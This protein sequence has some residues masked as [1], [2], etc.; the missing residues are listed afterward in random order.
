[1]YRIVKSLTRFKL[2]AKKHVYG[3]FIKVIIKE[4]VR[5]KEG[6]VCL[7]SRFR[8]LKPNN[9]YSKRNLVPAECGVHFLPCMK[10]V[11]KRT[12][13]HL[14]EV[15]LTD[16]ESKRKAMNRNWYNQKANPA[17]NTKGGNK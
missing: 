11:S 7:A 3:G 16:T 8:L 10:N 15:G 2:V 13:M 9:Q 17:L 4:G 12:K 1:M 5:A 6:L 14:I